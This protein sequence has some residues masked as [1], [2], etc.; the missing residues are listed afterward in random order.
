[1]ES[2][3]HENLVALDH[4]G[5]SA[6]AVLKDASDLP[7]VNMRPGITYW[8]HQLIRAGTSLNKHAQAPVLATLGP[9]HVQFRPP[10]GRIHI[11]ISRTCVLPLDSTSF[12]PVFDSILDRH[13]DSSS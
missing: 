13:D 1:M 8:K 3:K 4:V 11:A 2:A 6:V 7:V 9:I 12:V 10:T 5:D